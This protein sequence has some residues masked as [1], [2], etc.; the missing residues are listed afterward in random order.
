MQKNVTDADVNSQINGG[1]DDSNVSRSLEVVT[2]DDGI[3]G[4]LHQFR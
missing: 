3:A 2:A 1:N 4:P